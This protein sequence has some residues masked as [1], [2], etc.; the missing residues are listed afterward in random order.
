[1]GEKQEHY[2]LQLKKLSLYIILLALLK[3]VQMKGTLYYKKQI[4]T[5]NLS[6]KTVIH[7]CTS[8]DTSTHVMDGKIKYD[9]SNRSKSVGK[10]LNNC[11]TCQSHNYYKSFIFI[12][13]QKIILIAIL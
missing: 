13:F 10:Y 2:K 1:M 11:V 3:E 9:F 7:A 4:I 12:N 8:K 5:E 6:P